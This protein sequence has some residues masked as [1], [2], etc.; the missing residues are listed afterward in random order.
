MKKLIIG[1]LLFS[2]AATVRCH[3]I[4]T[5]HT[6]VDG[7]TVTAANMNTA[8]N[9]ATIG[10]AEVIAAMLA[11]NA[12]GT[13]AIANGAVTTN[14]LGAGAVTAAKLGAFNDQTIETVLDGANDYVPY[15]SAADGGNRRVTINNLLGNFTLPA[16][17]VVP[18]V[19]TSPPTGWLVCSGGTVGTVASSATLRAN[20]DTATLYTLLWN[21]TA[22]TELVIQDSAGSPTVRGAN[23]AAD[24]AANKRMPVPDLRGRA[25]FGKDDMGGS[26]ANRVTASG[27]GNPGLDGTKMANAGGVDRYTLLQAQVPSYNIS[28]PFTLTPGGAGATSYI[29]GDGTNNSAVATL[30]SGGSGNAHPQLNPA[31]ILNYIIK[32]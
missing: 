8:V 20:A 9:G 25:V 18:Y 27:T 19:G 6:F 24:F 12:V 21:S 2:L 23:A 22:N 1:L 28:L 5:G 32:Y 7:E 13:T 10:S 14:Q 16:G 3:A 11:A 31:L 4:T 17:M 30:A 29:A 15:Y 26:A